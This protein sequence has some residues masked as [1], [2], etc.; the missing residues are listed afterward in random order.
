MNPLRVKTRPTKGH[1]HSLHPETQRFKGSLTS[2]ASK[3]V[4]LSAPPIAITDR[5]QESHCN[6]S[7]TLRL[8]ELLQKELVTGVRSPFDREL[9][10]P[11]A[12]RD[13]NPTLAL[14]STLVCAHLCS[15]KPPPLN[16]KTP[17]C[18]IRIFA[19]TTAI[20]IPIQWRDP[21]HSEVQTS[22]NC[23]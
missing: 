17:D 19:I 9:R 15:T 22:S 12:L 5:W 4:H 21:V 14:L 8:P 13:S 11:I 3:H 20:V 2:T 7:Q 18:A 10:Y 16:K 23:K 1:G 6:R